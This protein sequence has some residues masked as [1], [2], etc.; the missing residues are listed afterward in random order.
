MKLINLMEIFD[1][2]VELEWQ[3]NGAFELST[4]NEG[5]SIFQLQ[6]ERKNFP[7]T[8]DFDRCKVG[9]VSFGRKDIEHKGSEFSSKAAIPSTAPK[10]Y[11]AVVNGLAEKFEN[12][13]VFYFDALR[14]HSES[15]EDYKTKMRIYTAMADVVKKQQECWYYESRWKTANRKTFIVSKIRMSDEES[16][17]TGFINPLKE[18]MYATGM[19]EGCVWYSEL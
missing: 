11:G 8:S 14:R 6:I 19:H 4:F 12:Y 5:G 18:A 2:N 13:D 10:V 17:R 15:D 16:N 7:Y 9:E 3:Q 1:H